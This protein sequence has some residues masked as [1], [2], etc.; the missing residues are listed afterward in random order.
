MRNDKMDRAT[1]KAPMQYL[2]AKQKYL[3]PINYRIKINI[4][5]TN[6]A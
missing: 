4:N 1:L 6:L 3:P 5:Q 2:R